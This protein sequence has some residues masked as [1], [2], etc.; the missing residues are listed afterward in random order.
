MEAARN[1]VKY[2]VEARFIEL[3]PDSL[4]PLAELDR[5]VGRNPSR[6]VPEHTTLP[7]GPWETE[8]GYQRVQAI[9]R[10]LAPLDEAG[11]VVDVL[12]GWGG[13]GQEP[14]DCCTVGGTE[15]WLPVAWTG[16]I[17]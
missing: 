3:D 2:F 11:D 16:G 7:E 15:S 4:I 9:H 6:A 12:F 14:P 17:M 1:L 8:G 5:L 10:G 13:V